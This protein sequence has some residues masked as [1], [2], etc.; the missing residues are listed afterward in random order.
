MHAVRRQHGRTVSPRSRG[1]AG[2]VPAVGPR[3]SRH[4]RAAM[5]L[6]LKILSLAF[7]ILIIFGVV[8]GISTWLQHQV[9]RQ[10]DV[11][12]RYNNPLRTVIAQFDVLTYEYEL[13]IMRALRRTDI[14]QNELE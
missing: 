9:M 14:T 6:R 11:L 2:A 4:R 13:I 3:S 7:V 8:V 1:A 10:I 12:T 5:T